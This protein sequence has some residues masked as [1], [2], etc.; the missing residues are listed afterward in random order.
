MAI[1]D[2]FDS[3]ESVF[4]PPQQSRDK[5]IKNYELTN[6]THYPNILLEAEDLPYYRIQV[7]SNTLEKLEF[8]H[9]KV[10]QGYFDVYLR[11]GN[12]SMCIGMVHSDNLRALLQNSLYKDIKKTLRLSQTEYVEGNMMLA[13]CTSPL[14]E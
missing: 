3:A 13:Y 4:H 8:I 12:R 11:M 6:K 5:Q 14:Y 1:K 2:T 7:L 9:E 10:P